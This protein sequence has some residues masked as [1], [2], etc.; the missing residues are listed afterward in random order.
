MSRPLGLRPSVTCGC[1]R[2]ALPRSTR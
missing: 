2:V 1:E